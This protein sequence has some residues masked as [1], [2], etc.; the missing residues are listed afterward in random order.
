MI[1]S[2]LAIPELAIADPLLYWTDCANAIPDTIPDGQE[3][4]CRD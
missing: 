1:H 2:N 3:R 4:G